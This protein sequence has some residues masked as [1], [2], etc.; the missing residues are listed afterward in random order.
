MYVENTVNSF[1]DI[2]VADA[3]SY[4]FQNTGL[5][6]GDHLYQVMG[7]EVDNLFPG[8]PPDTT[9]L[10]QS[11][12][13]LGTK[14]LFANMTEYDWPSGSSV[15]ATGS[16]QWSWGLDD[17]VSNV[18]PMLTDPAVQQATRNIFRHWGA[19]PAQ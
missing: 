19:S 1:G 18:H 9:V 16:M 10:A 2:V 17:F 5:Q 15:V 8:A 3:S 4:V 6:N 13:L 14:T 12:Y 11:P 7:Y